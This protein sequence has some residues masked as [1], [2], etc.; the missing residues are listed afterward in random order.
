MSMASCESTPD[1][2]TEMAEEPGSSTDTMKTSRKK[3]MPASEDKHTGANHSDSSEESDNDSASDNLSES[4]G[5]SSVSKTTLVMRPVVN[6]NKGA[7]K[8]RVDFKQ[9]HTDDAL[10]KKVHCTACG[11]QVN[12]FQ[13]NSVTEHPVLK[14]L[15]CKS[16]CKYYR[17]DDISKDSDGMDEQCRWCA[18]GG[19]LICCDFC[20]NAFC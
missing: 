1:Q 9:H 18:E 19:K 20:N 10:Q 13:R 12:Q 3:S 5:G 6:E 17:S 15:I 14:V 16:C 8:L 4:N 11:Q 7:M 2:G